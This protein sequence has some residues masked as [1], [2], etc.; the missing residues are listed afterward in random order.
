ME[1]KIRKI[2]TIRFLIS[3]FETE[4]NTDRSETSKEVE[5]EIVSQREKRSYPQGA[6][7]GPWLARILTHY[8]TINPTSKCSFFI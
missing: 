2:K 4:I 8:L 6:L 7:E 5:K 3:N 1:R